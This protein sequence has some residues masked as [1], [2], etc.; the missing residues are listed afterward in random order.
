[1]NLKT[2]SAF[3]AF[4]VLPVFA[5]YYYYYL[6]GETKTPGI[7]NNPSPT[8]LVYKNSEYGFNFKLPLDWQGFTVVKESW[9]GNPLKKDQLQT[10]P[11]LL[12][13]NPKWTKEAPYEDLPVLIFTISQ[14]DMYLAEDYAV[15]AAPIP[16][17]KLAQNNKYVFALPARRDFD[18]G[19]YVKKAQEI[20]SNN[21]IQTFN[22]VDTLNN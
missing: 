2:L 14:W 4:A 9:T 13:R 17:T 11:K 3:L 12:I 22:I 10:G 18:Y 7:S 5:L 19:I 20:F 8:C 16:A 1:M 15:S 21:P 6:P